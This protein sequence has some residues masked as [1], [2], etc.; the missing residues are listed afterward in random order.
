MKRFSITLLLFVA[1]A[2]ATPGFSQADVASAE[3]QASLLPAV[4]PSPVV[5]GRNNKTFGSVGL[6]IQGVTLGK[7]SSF[8][9]SVR[10]RG[11]ESGR[12]SPVVDYINTM[13][14]SSA[15][16]HLGR[17]FYGSTELA[18]NDVKSTVA[19]RL[20]TGE[21][22]VN[23]TTRG[24]VRPFLGVGGGV[25]LATEKRESGNFVVSP[26]YIRL[27]GGDYQFLGSETYSTKSTKP[28][29]SL[30]LGVKVSPA[31]H[32]T[33]APSARQF[34]GKGVKFLIYGVGIGGNF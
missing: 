19:G 32:F 34:V 12:V 5:E 13:E 1:F 15:T 11:N 14:I 27:Y 29:G 8:V 20:I 31:K 9:P 4:A 10:I 25:L 6:Y 28:L 17:Q 30:E 26:E 3:T 16:T 7:G 2:T 21:V 18:G 33:I 23:L 22:Q 24:R